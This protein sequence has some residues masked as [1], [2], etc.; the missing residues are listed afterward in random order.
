MPYRLTAEQQ[1]R[2][3]DRGDAGRV[4]AELLRAQ[5]LPTDSVVLALPRGGIPIAAPVADALHGQLDVLVV[6]KLGLPGQPEL[7]MGAIAGVE[8][9][10]EIIRNETVLAAAEV[11][12]DVFERVLNGELAA[13]LEREA[14][15]RQGRPAV[16]VEG[17]TAVLVDD[18]LATG[19]T[20]RAAVAAV[21][22]RQPARI[23]VAVP[24]GSAA[25]CAGLASAVDLLVCPLQP[26]H[27][28][29]VGQ[30]Y[31]DF[32]PTTE[33]EIAQVLGGG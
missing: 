12:D 20:M 3:A 24:V 16:A 29:A 1:R 8:D 6:R 23:V 10:V 25:A 18:G 27:F 2:Y 13:L 14:G 33:D 28:R 26:E 7:A 4:L 31:F 30:A 19:S 17:R 5:H 21:R 15:Y 32:E 9:A 22:R 11:P